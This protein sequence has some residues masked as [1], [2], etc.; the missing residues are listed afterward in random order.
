MADRMNGLLIGRQV[1]TSILF[2]EGRLTQHVVGVAKAFLLQTLGIRQ[3]IADGFT[4]H[5]LPAHNPHRHVDALA[6]QWLAAF[7]NQTRQRCGEPGFISGGGQAASD[8]QP[9]GRCIY[10]QR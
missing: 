3:C 2:S 8:Q 7:G 6:D 9:P 4:G 1:A 5:E 10:E